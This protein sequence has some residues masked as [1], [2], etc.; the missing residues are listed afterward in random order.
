MA[1]EHQATDRRGEDRG[2]AAM[3]Y[4]LPFRDGSISI[5]QARMPTSR[6]GF[7][8]RFVLSMRLDRCRRIGTLMARSRSSSKLRWL[9]CD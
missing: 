6:P 2:E 4:L 5:A 7:S 8:P 9:R 1:Q 3:E